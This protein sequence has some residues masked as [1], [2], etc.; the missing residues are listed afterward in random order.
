MDTQNIINSLNTVS[1]KLFKSIEGEVYS[2]IDDLVNITPKI[3]KEQPL[4]D[5]FFQDKINLL[6]LIAN[7][8]I[9][10]YI[11]YFVILCVLRINAQNFSYILV[12]GGIKVIFNF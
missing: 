3:Y 9:L 10:F 7:S 12:N 4:K 2:R 5:F 6:V 8:L 11:I 1:E